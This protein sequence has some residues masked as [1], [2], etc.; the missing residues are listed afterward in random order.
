V[1][2][3]VAVTLSTIVTDSK[4]GKVEESLDTHLGE[5]SLLRAPDEVVEAEDETGGE[6]EG[7][8]LR[9]KES[10]GSV[11]SRRKEGRRRKTHELGKLREKQ[12][13]DTVE[14]D[15]NEEDVSDQVETTTTGTSG[16]LTEVE[17][18]ELERVTGEDAV[19]GGQISMVDGGGKGGRGDV[20]SAGGSVDTES[21]GLGRND[22][23][24]D[25]AT[26]CRGGER[27]F[28]RSK[29]GR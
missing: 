21:E 20:R 29:S 8:A 28:S 19:A 26:V 11:S 5:L 14:T 10:R 15:T 23:T 27:R 12:S 1:T 22:D 18:V 24:K 13:L 4:T 16:A 7:T 6:R 17:R 25:T 2:G 9:E 3:L